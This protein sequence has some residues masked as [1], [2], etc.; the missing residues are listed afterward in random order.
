ML[1]VFG[2]DSD[3]DSVY[4]SENN[5]KLYLTEFQNIKNNIEFKND[6]IS[7]V[8]KLTKNYHIEILFR[9]ES[10]YPLPVK[11]SILLIDRISGKKNMFMGTPFRITCEGEPVQYIGK[12]AF[13]K[14]YTIEDFIILP[15]KE[16]YIA[17]INLEDYYDLSNPGTYT[18]KYKSY[19]GLHDN[20]DIESLI[21]IESNKIEFEK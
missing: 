19:Y 5:Q 6:Y 17:N 15:S 4:L 10:D 7:C 2:C 21:R 18:L 11:K 8:V 12:L 1:S 13:G 9:N 20:F 16:K 14:P 3:P